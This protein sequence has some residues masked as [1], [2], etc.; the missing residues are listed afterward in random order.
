[1][2]RRTS[3][4][5]RGDNCAQR[6]NRKSSSN[7]GVTNTVENSIR[8]LRLRNNARKELTQCNRNLDLVGG[9]VNGGRRNDEGCEKTK[10][11]RQKSSVRF[12]DKNLLNMFR[13]NMRDMID[14]V[15]K[16]YLQLISCSSNS[17]TGTS[18]ENVSRESGQNTIVVS[19]TIDKFVRYVDKHCR[20]FIV[21]NLYTNRFELGAPS[22]SRTLIIN[23]D[24]CNLPRG[25]RFNELCDKSIN[26]FVHHIIESIDEYFTM[27]CSRDAMNYYLYS[28]IVPERTIANV[29]IDDDLKDK[30]KKKGIGIDDAV[31][32]TRLRKK[33]Q[34]EEEE[35]EAKRKK[36]R[37][38]LQNSTGA[39]VIDKQCATTA[40]VIHA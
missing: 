27:V 15:S 21:L 20:H 22:M 12:L 16:S 25:Y 40:N 30:K 7:G 24:D 38:S 28:N 35:E 34:Q 6:N 26:E 1:M 10:K 17:M 13:E 5:N 14:L 32:A 8:A 4:V 29:S 23:Y 19:Q 18:H 9:N 3:F 37:N 33:L 36:S 2:A 11:R 39:D 31:M